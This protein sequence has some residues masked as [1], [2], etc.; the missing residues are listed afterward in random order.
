MARRI[1]HAVRRH[2][3]L[4]HREA[5]LCLV[6]EAFE[7]STPCRIFADFVI[8]L[9]LL[10]V[11]WEPVL[12][13]RATAALL[14]SSFGSTGRSGP[15]SWESGRG[16]RAVYLFCAYPARLGWPNPAVCQRS[17]PRPP[18]FLPPIHR[19]SRPYRVLS[20]EILPGLVGPL[21]LRCR[22]ARMGTDTDT[23]SDSRY[24]LA[25]IAG[26]SPVTTNTIDGSSSQIRP[27]H[28]MLMRTQPK[29]GTG[30]VLSS[31]FAFTLRVAPPPPLRRFSFTTSS[32]GTTR[33]AVR[34]IAR[35]AGK[36]APCLTTKESLAGVDLFL[37]RDRQF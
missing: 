22:I 6:R 23:D 4:G 34:C 15:L 17:G 9:S 1:P 8:Y 36:A 5:I 19:N 24:W 30:S 28:R 21:Y 3:G 26:W 2:E 12:T 16:G 11:V 7:G 10:F 14:L 29:W 33:L 31:T 35:N 32:R 37:L 13:I 27:S 20:K 18:H 25:D